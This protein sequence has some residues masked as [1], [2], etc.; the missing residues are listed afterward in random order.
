MVHEEDPSKATLKFDELPQDEN[1][2]DEEIRI[3]IEVRDTASENP[4]A[5]RTFY[6]QSYWNRSE[7]EGIWPAD[8][9]RLNVGESSGDFRLEVRRYSVSDSNVKVL[10]ALTQALQCVHFD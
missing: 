1:W 3:R 10:Q 2:I 5:M 6:E 8:L 7:F 9:G 4:D